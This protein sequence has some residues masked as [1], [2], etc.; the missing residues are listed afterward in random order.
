MT[1][2][3]TKTVKQLHAIAI[4]FTNYKYDGCKVNRQQ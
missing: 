3:R 4:K 2:N 1:G